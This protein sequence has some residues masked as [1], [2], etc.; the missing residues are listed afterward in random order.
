MEGVRYRAAEMDLA[1][2]DRI[3][4]YTDGVTEAN[5]TDN[6]LYGEKRLHAFANQNA[7]MDA[8][9]FLPALKKDIDLFVGQA[10][11]FDDITMLMLDFHPGQGVTK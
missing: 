3:F 1:P 7:H 9:H 10:P 4:L 11:Q 6:V 8:T 2:G 5:N